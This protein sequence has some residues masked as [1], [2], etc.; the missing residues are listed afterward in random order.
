MMT[1]LDAW[2]IARLRANLPIS[3]EDQSLVSEAFC[4]LVNRLASLAVDRRDD[5]WEGFLVGRSDAQDLM[6]AVINADTDR[7]PPEPTED[8]A[9]TNDGWGPIRLGTL[10]PA[11]P[12]P[13]EV[14]PLVA[15]R[16]VVESAES[17]G[18]PPDFVAVAM[19]AAAAGVIGRS[20]SL[21]LKGD[22]FAASSLF[23][24]LIGPP[25]DGKSPALRVACTAVRRIDETLQSQHEQAMDCWQKQQEAVGSDGKKAKPTLP[26]RPQRIDIDDA[27]ME[28]M[29]SLLADNSRGLIFVKDELSALMLGMNQYKGGKGSDRQFLLSA[30]SGKAIKIDRVKHSG[31]PVRVPHPCLT[32]IGAMTPDL[33]ASIGDPEGREDGFVDRFLFSYPEV[34]PV[35]SWNDRGVDDATLDEWAVLV[36]RLW[37][38]D[39]NFKEGRS[40]PHVASLTGQARIA[41]SEA[42]DS[43]TNEMNV[44]DFPGRL[45]GPWGKL[46]EY[47]GRLVLILACLDHAADPF[48]DPNAVPAITPQ[49]VRD[50]WQVVAYHKAHVRRVRASLGGGHRLGSDEVQVLLGWIRRGKRQSFST[51]EVTKDLTRFRDDRAALEDAL[52]WLTSKNIV[53]PQKET[54]RDSSKSGRKPAPRYDVNPATLKLPE[55]R[56]N[57]VNGGSGYDFGDSFYS[58][59]NCMEKSCT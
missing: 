21:R 59:A 42:Y 58:P 27:T 8:D 53:R 23:A 47:A 6:Q 20:V 7:P 34:R 4:P 35:P 14:L 37:T 45:R 54:P 31:I 13:V 44:S 1:P 25:S 3:S 48:A 12:F 46:G 36:A 5:A 2:L 22:Y 38:R 55:N 15:R 10:P 52:G 40:I 9:D 30:W 33:I 29:P 18:C 11:V 41:W 57:R 50:A 19:I 39:L 43:H 17:I 26:P 16:L 51:S 32:I 24:A 56:K 49:I 28:A